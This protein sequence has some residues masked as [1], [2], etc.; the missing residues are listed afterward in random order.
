[1]SEAPSKPRPSDDPRAALERREQLAD[2]YA[3]PGQLAA[4]EKGR[5]AA[6]AKAR[7]AEA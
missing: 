4:G 5:V 2:A 6:E 3:G 1:M 7:A